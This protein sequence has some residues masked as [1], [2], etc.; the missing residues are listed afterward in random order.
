[1]SD[2]PMHTVPG[3]FPRLTELYAEGERAIQEN[4]LDDAV[5]L[6]SEG[7]SL[8]DHFRQRYVTM[9]AQRAFAL[10]RLGR[11]EDAIA[12]YERAMGL[13]EPPTHQAQYHFHSALSLSA[14]GRRADAIEAHG[15]SIALHD[16]HPGPFHLRGKL[17]VDEGRFA[18]AISDF[19]RFLTMHTHPEVLQLRGYSKLSLGAGADAI[20]DLIE[21]QRLAPD[22]YTDYLLAWAGA[23]APDDELFYRSMESALHADRSYLQYFT[24]HPD[25]TRFASTDRFQRIVASAGG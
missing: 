15:R 5:A 9:Y 23:I 17:L 7:I 6:F 1:M 22:P 8:D 2:R 14:L 13:G 16:Q 3:L 20:A 12:D 11:H 21:S 19:D 18:E 25:F 10:Q 24:G 4:R